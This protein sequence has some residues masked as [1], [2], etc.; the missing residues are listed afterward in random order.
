MDLHHV[1]WFI[2]CYIVLG[3]MHILGWGSVMVWKEEVHC[4]NMSID[5]ERLVRR[6]AWRV[7][8]ECSLCNGLLIL[9]LG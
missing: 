9:V 6:E 3:V 5:L 8:D 7:E 1:Y 2:V 4:F